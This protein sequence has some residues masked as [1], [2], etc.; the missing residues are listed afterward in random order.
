[1]KMLCKSYCEPVLKFDTEKAS[2]MPSQRLKSDFTFS[3][4]MGKSCAATWHPP[5]LSCGAPK[6]TLAMSLEGKGAP[7]GFQNG[8]N[9]VRKNYLK[10]TRQQ[11]IKAA[12]S[13]IHISRNMQAELELPELVT[14][15]IQPIALLYTI[16][17]LY[18]AIMQKRLA[19]GL[20]D[21]L[22]QTQVGVSSR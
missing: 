8:G 2:P 22:W 13:V 16:Y 12:R 15:K 4:K 14:Q 1:M 20:D 19:Q 21:K 6:E 10:A 3:T 17:Q 11:I 9:K 5:G 18:A 7:S